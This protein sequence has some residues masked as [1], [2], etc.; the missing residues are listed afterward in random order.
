MELRAHLESIDKNS[1]KIIL[2][3]A[4]CV[5]KIK[6]S[7]FRGA[8]ISGTQNIYGENQIELDKN[9]DEIIISALKKSGLVKQ[10]ASE[11]QPNAIDVPN[12][13]AGYAVTLDPLDGSSC[14]KTNLAVGTIVG[15]Y[16]TPNVLQQGKNLCA[17]FYILY[18]P[19]TTL[20]YAAGNGVHEF[21]LNE[22]S[23]FILRT[24]NLKIGSDKI[25]APGGT[26][27]KYLPAHRKWMDALSARGYK[28]RFSG[29]FVADCNQILHYGG[30]FT[31]PG[32]VGKEGGK[33]RLL[34]EGNPLSFIIA[35]AGGSSSNGK[36]S[37]LEVIPEKIDQRVPVYVGGKEEIALIE[38]FFKEA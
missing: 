38:K 3:V 19:I 24:E 34:F 16:R 13:S 7:F 17:A 33:L 11:E 31:Y 30:V 32:L 15:I 14:V 18:G 27:D 21:A 12:A 20:V 4:G 10:I 8:E 36:I 28:I 2:A 23:Q 29:S 25:Y 6:E 5:P 1:A 35:N 26:A 37:L 9:A 22:K